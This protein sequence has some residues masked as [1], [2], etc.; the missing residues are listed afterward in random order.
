MAVAE[1]LTQPD[2]YQRMSTRSTELVK[3]YTY[4]HAAEGLIAGIRYA[5]KTLRD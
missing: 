1:L 4:A 3:A 5:L 2:L